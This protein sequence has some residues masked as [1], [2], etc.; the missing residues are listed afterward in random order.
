MK[1]FPP[2]AQTLLKNK[3]FVIFLIASG[4]STLGPT[5]SSVAILFIILQMTGSESQMSLVLFL[6]YL[7]M[8]FVPF[9]GGLIDRFSIRKFLFLSNLFRAFLTFL[10]SIGLIYNLWN[11][12]SIC[13]F[14]FL[15]GVI[16]SFSLAA[17]RIVIPSITSDIQLMQAN[18]LYSIV[19]Q[20]LT[21]IGFLISGIIISLIGP[22][23]ALLGEAT[24]YVFAAIA[25]MSIKM[26]YNHKNTELPSYFGHLKQGFHFIYKRKE[27]LF[28]AVISFFFSSILAPVYVLLPGMMERLDIGSSGFGIF[29]AISLSGMI[30]MNIF[31]MKTRIYKHAIYIAFCISAVFCSSAFLFLLIENPLTVLL[32]SPFLL[33]LSIGLFETRIWH[34][35]QKIIPINKYGVVIGALTSIA[36]IALPATFISLNYFLL[37]V[38]PR[39][40]FFMI[41]LIGYLLAGFCFTCR[42]QV[43]SQ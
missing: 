18:A 35:L 30:C 36:S 31:L 7:P 32:I 9:I 17:N 42:I 12:G 25:Y 10:L 21:L 26:V 4:Q 33:G 24:L 39:E 19:T 20:C 15:L 14:S 5:I 16:S 3:N 34:Y 37:F 13:L 28:L 40:V 29:M 1:D 43:V 41:A 6:K 8:I 27:I 22:D 38:S 23:L 2:K 11:I